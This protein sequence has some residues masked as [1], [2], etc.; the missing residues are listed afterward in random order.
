MIK[1]IERYCACIS[2]SGSEDEIREQIIGD[3][4]NHATSW[5][6]DETGNLTVFKKGAK[7]SGLK[8]LF[9]AH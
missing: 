3:I 1:T 4:K 5:E 2:P 9:S 8:I 6:V 7:A